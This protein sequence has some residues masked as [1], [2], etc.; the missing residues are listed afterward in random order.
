MAFGE[1]V[2]GY[3]QPVLNEREV[4]AGA[5][6][7][8]FI[9]M[10]VFWGAWYADL[11]LPAQMMIIA[12]FI[13]FVLRV[14]TPRYAPTL[15]LGRLVVAH[16]TPEYT[17]AAPK[18][19]AWWIG[20]GLAAFMLVTMIFMQQMSFLNFAVCGIC[21]ALLFMESSFGICLGCL[22]YNRV[23]KREITLC[24]GGVCEVRQRQPIQQVTIPQWL[25]LIAFGIALTAITQVMSDPHRHPMQHNGAN[26]EFMQQ[27]RG[28]GGDQEKSDAVSD[29]LSNPSLA[30]PVEQEQPLPHPHHSHH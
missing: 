18:R 28:Q 10:V 12:F 13:D 17:A 22:F 1:Q 20:L 26:H 14:V 4:R 11:M 24:A 8:F 2:A 19:F 23:L 16:Q 6:I 21:I 29:E 30:A 25:M 9:S 3:D 5:G 27:L 15:I 7:L